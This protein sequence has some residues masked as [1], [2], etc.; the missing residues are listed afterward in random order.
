MGLLR[1]A[2]FLNVIGEGS[3]YALFYERDR[4]RKREVN[5]FTCNL[6]LVS[7]HLSRG[8]RLIGLRPWLHCMLTRLFPGRSRGG[9]GDGLVLCDDPLYVTMFKI[10]IFCFTKI[11]SLNSYRPESRYA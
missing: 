8:S 6:L 10:R 7:S 3:R 2:K 9:F 11:S 5:T 4:P 1:L